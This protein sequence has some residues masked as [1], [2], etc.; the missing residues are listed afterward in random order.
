LTNT[1]HKL[2]TM[3]PH[4]NYKMYYIGHGT[5]IKYHHDT[6][7]MIKRSI[8]TKVTQKVYPLA[9]NKYRHIILSTFTL[10]S[11]PSVSVACTTAHLESKFFKANFLGYK[12]DQLNQIQTLLETGTSKAKKQRTIAFHVGDTNLVA[13]DGVGANNTIIAAAGLHD[14][15]KLTEKTW[16]NNENQNSQVF[17][18]QHAT[19]RWSNPMVKMLGHKYE[20]YHRP[21]RFFVT[22]QTLHD[23]ALDVNSS[24][25]MIQKEDLSDHDGLEIQ[26]NYRC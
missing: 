15:F 25:V 11:C 26:L 22:T 17:Q 9:R 20:K 24:Q 3:T 4:C 16:K 8:A 13:E 21:D 10:K 14:L 7:L 6:V 1:H 12:R 18:T 5:Q 2:L 23:K 19:W